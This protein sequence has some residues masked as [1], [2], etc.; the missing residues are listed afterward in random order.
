M[1]R[2]EKKTF[3]ACFFIGDC[4]VAWLSKKQNSISL[5]IAKAEYIIVEDY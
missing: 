5:S 4:L 2:T 1:L 3:G